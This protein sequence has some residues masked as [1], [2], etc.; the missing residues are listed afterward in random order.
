M[1]SLSHLHPH[2]SSHPGAPALTGAEY[3]P[4]ALGLGWTPKG[5]EALQTE[6]VLH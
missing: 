1:L 4:Q 5:T 2:P 3:G 6:K